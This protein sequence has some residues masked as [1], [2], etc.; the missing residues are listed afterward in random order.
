MI[1][2]EVLDE[3]R[4]SPDEIEV[5]PIHVAERV[6]GIVDPRRGRGAG[7]HE[8]ETT[9]SSRFQSVVLRDIGPKR[10]P[11]PIELGRGDPRVTVDVEFRQDLENGEDLTPQAVINLGALDAQVRTAQRIRVRGTRAG[12]AE[13]GRENEDSGSA[14][15]RSSSTGGGA[16]KRSAFHAG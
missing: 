6:Q 1:R 10:A 4:R 8:R 3:R 11:S 16:P 5:D 12:Q 9:R 14:H 2:I 15:F 7:D 13:N